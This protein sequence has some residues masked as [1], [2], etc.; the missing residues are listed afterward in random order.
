MKCGGD[1]VRNRATGW[2]TLLA[3][4][5]LFVGCSSPAVEAPTL[6]TSVGPQITEPSAMPQGSPPSTGDLGTRSA[7]TSIAA[8]A[9]VVMFACAS[10]SSAQLFQWS[11][12]GGR[13]SGTYTIATLSGKPPDEH[14]VS[15]HVSLSGVDADGSVSL[16][17]GDEP[18]IF[19]TVSPATLSVQA[20]QQDGHLAA[21]DCA[22]TNP[23]RWNADIGALQDSADQDNAWAA[24]A[25]KQQQTQNQISTA[26]RELAADVEDLAS[27]AATLDSNTTLADQIRVMQQSLADVESGW[28]TEQASTVCSYDDLTYDAET[29]GEAAGNV[30]GEQND[31]QNVIGDLKNASTGSMGVQGKIASVQADLATLRQLNASPET[32]TSIAVSAGKKAIADT[33][34]AITWA[35]G[36]SDQ[37]TKAA[38]TAAATAKAYAKK[39]CG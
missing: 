9:G 39:L 1:R 23:D 36:K 29:V 16:T 10:A 14:V 31:L 8:V 33:A 28:R 20:P 26:Q 21:I 38:T 2:V 12:G 35:L 11:E 17:I 18:E 30:A 27:A 15:T 5:V 4:S 7:E 22:A 37:V 3:A 25:A 6:Q 32:D 13:L 19:G 34:K 24:A